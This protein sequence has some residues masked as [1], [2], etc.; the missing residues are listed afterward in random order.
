MN[1]SGQAGSIARCMDG[2]GD[3]E[4]GPS[5]D[6]PKEVPG[7]PVPAPTSDLA[8]E[9]RQTREAT[10][11]PVC[12]GP[13]LPGEAISHCAGCGARLHVGCLGEAGGQGCPL[14]GGRLYSEGVSDRLTRRRELD[15]GDARSRFL[16]TL[17][18]AG[19][20]MLVCA[21]LGLIGKVTGAAPEQR[22]LVAL[23]GVMVVGGVALG[24]IGARAS[25]LERPT[26]TSLAAIVYGAVALL[27][28]CAG[29]LFAS[30]HPLGWS[31]SL[32]RLALALAPSLGLGAIAFAIA[33]RARARDMG[34]LVRGFSL[35]LASVELLAAGGL[36]ATALVP[37]LLRRLPIGEAE[38][39]AWAA[40][41]Q[42]SPPELGRSL[43]LDPSFELLQRELPF[44][45]DAERRAW[46]QA[47]RARIEGQL[48][49]LIEAGGRW[50]VLRVRVEPEPVLVARVLSPE[51]ELA[52]QELRLA[53]TGSGSIGWTDQRYLGTGSS[54]QSGLL[55]QLE[56]DTS[57]AARA[58]QA[59]RQIL[60]AGQPAMALARYAAL[61]A[62]LRSDPIVLQVRLRAARAVGGMEHAVALGDLIAACRPEY[63]DEGYRY[64]LAMLEEAPDRALQA[65]DALERRVGGDPFLDAQRAEVHRSHG[66]PEEATRLAL[67]AVAAV[68]DLAEVW[69]VLRD[70]AAAAEDHVRTRE[71]MERLVGGHGRDV[72]A[73]EAFEGYAEFLASPETARWQAWKA[74]RR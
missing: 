15:Q 6:A 14:C 54:L 23:L 65:L 32:A 55:A 5:D 63:G 34:R 20:W 37:T 69:R 53:R 33:W 66:D 18:F 60:H 36:I 74:Q 16:V 2:D 21:A 52:Y 45:N 62:E 26:T 35:L 68:P 11:C 12:H 72:E 3:R 24:A 10:R 67:Q 13:T 39:Q 27:A 22:T 1:E 64:E 43:D 70:C 4:P 50:D 48:R 46:V 19:V 29:L 28:L 31:G 44:T 30:R 58:H 51:G 49:D 59:I 17:V 25:R 57:S 61:P 47:L 56:G 38:A 8:I 42:Q 73:V 41:L 40:R 9:G 71:A 7:E